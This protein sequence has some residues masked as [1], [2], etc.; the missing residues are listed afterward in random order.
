MY[1]VSTSTGEEIKT[2]NIENYELANCF[3]RTT[4]T[5]EG[6]GIFTQKGIIKNASLLKNILNMLQ[7]IIG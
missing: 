5:S 2:V 3:S 7:F 6:V 4:L 1:S